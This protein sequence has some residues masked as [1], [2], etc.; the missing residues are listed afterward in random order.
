MFVGGRPALCASSSSSSQALA[1]GGD[2]SQGDLEE[3]EAGSGGSREVSWSEAD[4]RLLGPCL[5]LVKAAKAC[6]KRLLG[7][8]R[9]WGKADSAEQ[10][11]QLDDLADAAGDV[12]PR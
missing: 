4:R 3:E 12:S 10:V 9:A 7:A 11:A 5:G 1:E 8:V 6:L 2:P